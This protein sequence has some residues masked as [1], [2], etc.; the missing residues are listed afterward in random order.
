MVGENECVFSIQ[1]VFILK[2]E[3]LCFEFRRGGG[4]GGEGVNKD[5]KGLKGLNSLV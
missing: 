1:E 3:L 2:S 4:G 5:G